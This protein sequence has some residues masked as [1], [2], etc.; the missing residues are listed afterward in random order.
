MLYSINVCVAVWRMGCQF[1]VQKRFLLSL[2]K[3]FSQI[4]GFHLLAFKK[5]FFSLIS[6]TLKFT[7]WKQ[8]RTLLFKTV[9]DTQCILYI[10]YVAGMVFNIH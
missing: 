4:I 8:T 5:N 3:P 9:A 10:L 2:K 7:F 6:P 1:F